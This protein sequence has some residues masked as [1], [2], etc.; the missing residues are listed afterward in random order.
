MNV[1]ERSLS[2]LTIRGFTDREMRTP[3][4][5]LVAMY[6]PDSLRLNYRTK[7]SQNEFINTDI[8]SNSYLTSTPGTLDLELVFDARMPGNNLTIEQQLTELHEL[9]YAISP[10]TREPHFLAVSWGKLLVGG[11]AGRE[12][13]GRCIDYSINYTLFERDGTPLR[14]TVSLSLSADGSIQLQSAIN[15]LKAPST[16]VASAP[17][18][19]L[20]PLIAR[21]SN[22][23]LKDS[24]DYLTL[25]DQNNLDSF[26]DVKPGQGLI[27]SSSE[28]VQ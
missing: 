26:Y 24:V 15:N 12:F 28:G 22:S 7:Y 23:Y 25:A 3:V 10:A 1:L 13:N 19:T 11:A 20:L 4:G 16:I 14:A 27:A 5:S 21:Q 9:C 2:K 6:N 17:D 8:L 18:E